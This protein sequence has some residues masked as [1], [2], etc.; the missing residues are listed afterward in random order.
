LQKYLKKRLQSEVTLRR[1][2]LVSRRLHSHH[3]ARAVFKARYR[4]G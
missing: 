1:F 3:A 4:G 2:A